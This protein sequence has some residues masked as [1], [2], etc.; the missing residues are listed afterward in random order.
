MKAPVE[1]PVASDF[2]SSK[3]YLWDDE[4]YS[5]GKKSKCRCW[6]DGEGEGHVASHLLNDVEK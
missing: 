4:E 5:G 3:T 1:E 6:E 2:D